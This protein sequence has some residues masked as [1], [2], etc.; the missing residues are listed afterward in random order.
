VI[1]CHFYLCHLNRASSPRRG[2]QRAEIFCGAM[3]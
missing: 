1:L 2:A 3:F